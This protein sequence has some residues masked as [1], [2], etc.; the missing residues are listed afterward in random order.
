MKPT[1]ISDKTKTTTYRTVKL[2]VGKFIVTDFYI[3]GK[4]H[5]QTWSVPKGFAT[6][7]KQAYEP[8][9]LSFYYYADISFLDSEHLGGSTKFYKDMSKPTL[10]T[11]WSEFK[12]FNH[13]ICDWIPMDG[14]LYRIDRATPLM[15]WR[16]QDHIGGFTGKSY[17]LLPELK[18]ELEALPFTRNVHIMDI[19]HYNGGGK[20]VEFEYRNTT[21]IFNHDLQITHPKVRQIA[22]KYKKKEQED[23]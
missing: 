4:L 8:S 2:K 20:A 15:V 18:K 16:Y 5:E 13:V 14:N 9:K 11:D 6:T 17:C 12:G 10:I 21:R 22:K 19:P 3:D 23:Y 1:T 7:H